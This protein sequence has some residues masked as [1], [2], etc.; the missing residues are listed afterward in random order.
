M[1]DAI[2]SVV[3]WLVGTILVLYVPICVRDWWYCPPNLWISIRCLI[4]VLC[5]VAYPISVITYF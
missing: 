4:G 5:L 2:D 3:M 1:P